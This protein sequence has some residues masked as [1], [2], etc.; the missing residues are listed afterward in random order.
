MPTSTTAPAPTA[1][2]VMTLAT[3]AAELGCT[4]L[5]VS[6]L[7]AR[8]HITAIMVGDSPRVMASEVAR[9]VSAGAKDFNAPAFTGHAS[10]LTGQDRG[11]FL[12]EEDHFVDPFV[13]AAL[14]AAESLVLPQ[15]EIESR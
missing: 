5:H 8:G 10:D 11:W 14:K 4:P 3:V 13:S 2:G 7:I 9:Y 1:S 6:R 15:P 12:N